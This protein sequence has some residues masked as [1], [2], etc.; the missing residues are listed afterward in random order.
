MKKIIL[1]AAVAALALPSVANATTFAN[2]SDSQIIYFGAPDTT[3]YGQVFSAPGGSL[4]SWTF[5][6][7]DPSTD[8][9][10]LVIANWDGNKAVGPALYQGL[11]STNSASGAFTAHTYSGIN[12]ALTAATSYIAYLTVAGVANPTPEVAVSG[13][14]T[15]PLGGGF[16]Y[17]NSSLADPLTLNNNWSAW[18]VPN[19]QYSATFGVSAAVPEPAAWAM[20]IAGFGLV[21]GAMRKRAKVSVSYA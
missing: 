8:G 15:S 13:S 21:G 12:L 18:V 6:T 7:A 9:A 5:F 10:K 1:L 2:T 4:Q 11:T 16:R 17:L 14:N 19:M 20:M 3:S